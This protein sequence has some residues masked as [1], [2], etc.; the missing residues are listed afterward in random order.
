MCEQNRYE[1]FKERYAAGQLPWDDPL[2]PPEVMATVDQLPPGR[3]VDLGCGYGRSS[4]YLAQH[5]WT[6]DGVDYVPQ[7][8]TEAR[9]RAQ[10]AN[11]AHRIQFHQGSVANLHFLTGQYTLAVDV[12][13][14][15][16]LSSGEQEGYRDE[17]VRL[18][19]PGA[20]YLLFARTFSGSED[21]ETGPP[22]LPEAQLRHLF[23]LDFKLERVEKGTT[24]VEGQPVWESTWFWFRKK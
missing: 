10:Q 7:A 19:S 16:S 20:V 17:L 2:P 12:G 23:D 21:P 11:M 22:S 4:I 13:C 14:L 1:R 8:V 5:G 15:H 24:Q 3:A 18:L 6:V 9:N